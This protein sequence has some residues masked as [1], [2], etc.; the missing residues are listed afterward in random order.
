[1]ASPKPIIRRLGLA[2]RAM[3]LPFLGASLLPFA[4]GVAQAAGPVRWI[5]VGMAAL[6]VAA[7]HLAANLVNELA[8]A[9]NGADAQDT[10]RYELFGGSKIL[11]EGRLTVTWYATAAATSGSLAAVFLVALAW[12]LR[13]AV[14]LV[15]GGL[16]GAF[17]WAY[18]WP[19]IRLMSRGLGEAAVAVLFG[20]VTVWAGWTA[21]GGGRPDG[22]VSLVGAALGLF[23]AGVLL[24]NE[25]PDAAGDG[26]VGKRTLVVRAGVARGWL[27]YAAVAVAGYLAVV[28]CLILRPSVAAGLAL[29][30]APMSLLAADR[31]RHAVGDK[32][33]LLLASRLAIAT[34]GLVA[35]T[36]VCDGL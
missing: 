26:R 27:L 10:A 13:S 19:P 23:T 16:A 4:A 14:P 2:C 22:R 35:L 1:M 24:A 32:P 11:Q 36:L 15:W 18:S 21:A 28:A 34:Q 8:D 3:R 5:S 6:A 31:L 29:A 30:T 20:P 9:A 25:V 7:V 12:H 17:A 33:M